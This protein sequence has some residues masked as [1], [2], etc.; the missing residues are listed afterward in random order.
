MSLKPPPSNTQAAGGPKM[1]GG[2]ESLRCGAQQ[3]TRTCSRFF[4]GLN[5]S[6]RWIEAENVCNSATLQLCN[7]AIL[8][9]CNS[10]ILQL[11]NSSALQLCNSA[12]PATP[13][14]QQFCN[15]VNPATQ[16]LSNSV[17]LQLCNSATLQ[18]CNS[19]QN[20]TKR[21]SR[22]VA[23]SLKLRDRTY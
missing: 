1:R 13:A 6:W 15:S 22:S 7:S 10:A 19:R 11:C 5:D 8:Q 17:A 9:L 2:V 4:E 20:S 14:T 3:S 21:F 12:T 18:L 16:Q 23:L